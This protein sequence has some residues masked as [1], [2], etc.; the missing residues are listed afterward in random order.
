MARWL[1]MVECEFNWK[2][3][4][5]SCWEHNLLGVYSGLAWAMY[6]IVSL[7]IIY[8]YSWLVQNLIFPLEFVQKKAQTCLSRPIGLPPHLALCRYALVCEKATLDV[9]GIRVVLRTPF[10]DFH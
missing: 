5:S 6:H 3:C 1:N 7:C 10:Q 8:I 9:R 2:S 4:Q